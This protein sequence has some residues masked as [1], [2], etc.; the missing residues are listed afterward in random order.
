[1]PKID[2]KAGRVVILI[3]EVI[4]AQENN[5]KDNTENENDA[6]GED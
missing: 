6:N 2:I 3:E 1:V 4:S 5:E